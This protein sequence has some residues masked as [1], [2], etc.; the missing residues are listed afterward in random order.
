M[1]NKDS[2][3]KILGSLCE[4]IDGDLDQ[5]LCA[6]IE[7][8]MEGC[9]DCR[10]VVDT[11]RKTIYLYRTINPCLDVPG[12]VRERLF[13]TLDLEEFIKRKNDQIIK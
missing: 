13:Q 10:I 12:E 8:H 9:E 1:E 11:L 6:E 5:E 7:R 3:H 2:C 4:Y